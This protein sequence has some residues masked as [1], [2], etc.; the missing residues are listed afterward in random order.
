MVEAKGSTNC[1]FYE[2]CSKVAIFV[3]FD[4]IQI[5]EL[6]VGIAL[7]ILVGFHFLFTSD[8]SIHYDP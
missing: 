7:Y 3:M 5:L 4:F 6:T 2:I 8:E 1:P